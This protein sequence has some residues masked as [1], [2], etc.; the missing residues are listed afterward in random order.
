MTL[1]PHLLDID[2]RLVEVARNLHLLGAISWPEQ[3]IDVFLADWHKRQPRL[4]AVERPAPVA[5]DIIDRLRA[6]T[7]VPED[8]PIA[9]FLRDTA[10]SYLRACRI[11]SGAGTEAGFATSC[12]LYGTPA[13][14]LPGSSITHRQAADRILEVTAPL[15]A[16]TREGDGDYCIP[17]PVVAMEMKQRFAA[18]FGEHAP[19]V[20]I[21]STLSAKA[22]ASATRVRLRGGTCFSE[23]DIEQLTAHEGFVHAA[24]SLNGRR[25]PTLTALSLSAPRTTATQEGLATLAELITGAMDLARLRRLALR[26]VAIDHA[27]SGADFIDV[28]RF[29]LE[30]GQSEPE[31]AYSAARIFRAGDVRG[32]HVFTK[33]V[34]YM[35]GLL[36][37]HTFLRRAIIDVRPELVARLFVGRLTASDV[38][39]LE[40]HFADG[41]IAP[42][43]FVPEWARRLRSLAA[44]MSFSAIIDRIDLANVDMQRLWGGT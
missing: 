30:Q 28:F 31:S 43:L 27:I 41:T 29:F 37:V 3:V 44:H 38:L 2:R 42:P 33:D 24:T 32:R 8:E 10:L 35:R 7:D 9:R 40:P 39:R 23:E 19:D 15:E 34:V 26:V 6:L 12:E 14:L 1:S 11:I 22:A 21:D 17:A 4:P 18:F 36:A 20:V 13:E 16:A 25:Q 5:R